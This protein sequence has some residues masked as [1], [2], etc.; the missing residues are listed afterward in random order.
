MASTEVERS[1]TRGERAAPRLVLVVLCLTQ[2]TS[3]GVLFYAFP[4][5]AP[6]IVRDT[7]WSMPTV[8][9]GFSLAQIVSAVVG[10]P[11]GRVLDHR[12]PQ[13]VM[14]ADSVLAVGAVVLLARSS[15]V[16]WP[17]A[18]PQAVVSELY[19]LKIIVGAH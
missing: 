1:G 3:W 16:S 8:I 4:V 15:R 12:G 5:L 11:V 14:T 13:V 9:A 18:E 2:I 17:P 7:G 6:T 19:S 10:I